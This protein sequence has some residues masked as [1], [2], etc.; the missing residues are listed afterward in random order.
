M[1]ILFTAQCKMTALQ[2][3]KKSNKRI[4][5]SNLQVKR[6]KQIP[7]FRLGQLVRTADIR[8]GFLEK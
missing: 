3:S 5:Y 4:F 2:V 8:R 7:K 1:I 6:Q